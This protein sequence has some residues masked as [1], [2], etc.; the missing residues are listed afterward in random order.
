MVR[1]SES[2]WFNEMKSGNNKLNIDEKRNIAL[3]NIKCLS[4]QL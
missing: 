2:Y 1:L 3:R 4:I